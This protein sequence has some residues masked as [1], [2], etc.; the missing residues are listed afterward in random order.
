MKRK[1]RRRVLATIAA[2]VGAYLLAIISFRSEPR[3]YVEGYSIVRHELND[4]LEFAHGKVTAKTCCG[5]FPM[6]TYEARPDGRW[7]WH[8]QLSANV[9]TG[10][11]LVDSHLFWLTF[12]GA[13]ELPFWNRSVRRRLLTPFYL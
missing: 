13:T 9:P 11:V 2:G 10:D 4:T 8:S 7:V 6:G 1:I 3:G 12:S 5:D